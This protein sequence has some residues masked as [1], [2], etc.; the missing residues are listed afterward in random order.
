MTQVPVF[1]PMVAHGVKRPSVVSNQRERL[2]WIGRNRWLDVR[3]R[4]PFDSMA[5]EKNRCPSFNRP[6]TTAPTIHG[7]NGD[8]S[9]IEEPKT[10]GNN[11]EE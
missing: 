4:T 9:D 3:G 1:T 8:H 6:D 10:N 11:T 7:F 5:I 2:K